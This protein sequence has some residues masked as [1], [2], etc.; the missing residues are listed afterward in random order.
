MGYRV[1]FLLKATK[2]NT[3][4]HLAEGNVLWGQ[5]F[6]N[7]EGA[8]RREP[9]FSPLLQKGFTAFYADSLKLA[10]QNYRSF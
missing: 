1:D 3:I 2:F 4:I 9:N 7:A 5:S 8:V 10:K 6:F